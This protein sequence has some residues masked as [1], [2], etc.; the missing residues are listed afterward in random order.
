[1]LLS[2]H[3]PQTYSTQVDA[4]IHCLVS[5]HLRAS[6]TYLSLGFDLDLNGVVL[7]G[8]ALF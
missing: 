5:L 6:Y 4:A 1:M 7:E 2:N 3:E 8:G